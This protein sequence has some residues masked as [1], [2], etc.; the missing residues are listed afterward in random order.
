MKHRR[1]LIVGVILTAGAAAAVLTTVSAPGVETPPVSA[2]E[3]PAEITL[4]P[5]SQPGN[6][7]YQWAV[8]T[9]PELTEA[10]DAAV[11]ALNAEASGTV[12]YFG[13]D[14][15]YADGTTT[16]GAMQ[17]DF[18]VRLPVEDLSKEEDFGNWVAQVMGYV[19][20]IPREDLQAPNY[21]FV[22]F[23]FEKDETGHIVFRVPIQKYL[24]EAQGMSGA[25]LFRL[26]YTPP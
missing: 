14:C 20:Q 2:S 7:A 11:K 15:R 18:R 17:A 5:E 26:F 16:F 24:D 9:A 23:W 1:N 10:F 6:C 21:G 13:E 25:E 8:Q 4:A 19:T 12:E 22:E 3:T